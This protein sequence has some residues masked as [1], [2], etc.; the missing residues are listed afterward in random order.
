MPTA[1]MKA[2]EIETAVP[3]GAAGISKI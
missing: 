2:A 3:E 1:P